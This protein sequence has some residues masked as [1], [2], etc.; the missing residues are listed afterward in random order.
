M[1]CL[2]PRGRDSPVAAPPKRVERRRPAKV[3]AAPYK[4]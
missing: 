2:I 3:N 1:Q 4:S